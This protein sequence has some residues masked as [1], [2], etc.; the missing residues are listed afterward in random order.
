MIGF[1]PGR[2]EYLWAE[3]VDLSREGL[4]CISNEAVDPLTN[5]FLMLELTDGEKM[6]TIRCEG[7]VRH[8]RMEDGRCH[9]GV[10]I[11]GMSQEDRQHFEAHLSALE[12]AHRCED[13]EAALGEEP[14][15]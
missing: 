6:I 7:F 5:L 13:R 14:P 3:G 8:A 10:K 9:F 15:A 12:S 1:F 2:E 11:E 4:R